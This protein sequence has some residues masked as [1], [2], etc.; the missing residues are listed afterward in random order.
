MAYMEFSDEELRKLHHLKLEYNIIS[1]EGELFVVPRSLKTKGQPLVLKRFNFISDKMNINKIITIEYLIANKDKI[2]IPEIILPSALASN[3]KEKII[4][5][6]MPYITNVNLAVLFED[7]DISS[8]QKKQWLIEINNILLKIKKLRDQ[9]IIPNFYL[10]DLHLG[11][12]IYNLKTNKVNVIDIDSCRILDNKP[13]P[14]K[15]LDI[16]SPIKD[17]P[18]KY[19]SNPDLDYN[20][21]YIANQDSDLYCY[22]MMILDYLFRGNLFLLKKEVY[23]DYLNYLNG[24]GFSKQLTDVYAKL[25]DSCPNDSIGP[26][27]S[28]IELTDDMIRRSKSMAYEGKRKYQLDMDTIKRIRS[29]Y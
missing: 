28:E 8:R 16:D 12:F 18:Q 10:N 11:N 27:L 1:T 22:N 20:G 17:L 23:D 2:N 4:G 15:Y 24:I 26:Y 19:I 21:N 3:S 14:A 7:K 13:F 6:I 9:N 25:Y 29:H 5:F